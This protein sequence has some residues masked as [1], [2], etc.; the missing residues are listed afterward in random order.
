MKAI[1]QIQRQPRNKVKRQKDYAPAIL[2][3]MKQI[4]IPLTQTTDDIPDSKTIGIFD[5]PYNNTIILLVRHAPGILAVW[6]HFPARDVIAGVG[7]VCEHNDAPGGRSVFC[8]DPLQNPVPP[9]AQ[10]TLGPLWQQLG[11]P[12]DKQPVRKCSMIQKN[13]WSISVR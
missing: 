9:M 5:Y 7:V 3:K 1:R 8:P 11:R 2:T 12:T 13:L 6:C 10:L 4:G